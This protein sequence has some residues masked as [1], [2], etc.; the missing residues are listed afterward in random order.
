MALANM[1]L[2]TK[3][4]LILGRKRKR[5]EEEEEDGG[6]K[7]KPRYGTLNFVWKLTLI[8][9]S[10]ILCMNFHA[11][12][13]SGLSPNL[14]FSRGSILTKNLWKIRWVKPHMAQDGHR[15]PLLDWI[16]G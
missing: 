12:L 8:M 4:G 11:W 3:I 7:I 2:K 9:D 16:H 15:I 13:V 1:D 6:A 10:M 14:G 5:E